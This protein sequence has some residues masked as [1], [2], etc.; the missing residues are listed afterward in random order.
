MKKFISAIHLVFWKKWR[1]ENA[2][3]LEGLVTESTKPSN[4]VPVYW[5]LEVGPSIYRVVL[6]ANYSKQFSS[7]ITHLYWLHSAL[8]TKV[9]ADAYCV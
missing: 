9:C 2:R 7:I 4:A 3:G 6:L 5:L 1:Q 8:C